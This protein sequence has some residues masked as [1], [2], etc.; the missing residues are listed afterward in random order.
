[1]IAVTDPAKDLIR[2]LDRPSDGVL[3]LEPTEE[4]GLGFVMGEPKEGDQVVE[5]GGEE[6]LHINGLISQALDG[7]VLDAVETP[8]GMSLTLEPPQRRDD[9]T[10]PA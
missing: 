3:R 8:E 10:G 9:G 2:H 4:A 1:M 5:A 7:A 6:L